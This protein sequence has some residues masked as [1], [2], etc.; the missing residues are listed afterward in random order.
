M[1]DRFGW[2]A[3][4]SSAE[5]GEVAKD[6]RCQTSTVMSRKC[7]VEEGPDGKPVQKCEV[8]R[9]VLRHCP[10]KPPEEVESTR[11]ETTSSI[12]DPFASSFEGLNSLPSPFP[13]TDFWSPFGGEGEKEREKRL[14]S[15]FEEMLQDFADFPGFP[16]RVPKKGSERDQGKGKH[17]HKVPFS[18]DFYENFQDA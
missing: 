16:G 5:E 6:E 4:S 1:F 3:S 15:L 10:G 18:T 13:Q 11:E 14:H 2:N 7:F 9:R 12:P 17:K 8:L